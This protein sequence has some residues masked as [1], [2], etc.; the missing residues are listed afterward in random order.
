MVYDALHKK[1]AGN[2][3]AE[4]TVRPEKGSVVASWREYFDSNRDG[5]LQWSE[6]KV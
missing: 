4:S 2:E 3:G 6:F 1:K 5:L